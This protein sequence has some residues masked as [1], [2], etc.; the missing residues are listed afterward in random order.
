MNMKK[1]SLCLLVV[2]SFMAVAT[3]KAEGNV[4]ELPYTMVNGK[5]IVSA[6]VDGINGK[7]VFDTGAPFYISSAIAKKINVKDSKTQGII[8]SGGHELNVSKVKVGKV[9]FGESSTITLDSVEANVIPEGNIMEAFGVDGI[10]G[11]D[12]FVNKAV[13]FDSKAKKILIADGISQWKV[14]PRARVKMDNSNDQNIP[15]VTVNLGRGV[16]DSPMFDSGDATFF[17]LSEAAAEQGVVPGKAGTVVARGYGS[18]GMGLGGQAEKTN[19]MRVVLSDLR[20]GLGKFKNVSTT[21]IPGNG[22][23][24]GSALLDYGYVTLD[25][26]NSAFYFEPFDTNPV[27]M[28]KKEWNIGVTLDKAGHVIIS[29]VWKDNW[30]ASELEIGDRVIEVNG[31]KI[32]TVDMGEALRGNILK[33]GADSA[34]IKVMK[35]DGRIV[36]SVMYRK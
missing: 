18:T 33:V 30:N 9:T 12:F 14:N 29:A 8:D 24:F 1:I 32:D 17:S 35:A 19:L 22:S 25:N 7:F 28:Y 21:T 6:N 20:I 10:I 23:R 31:K 4:T 16:M 5:M 15:F 27:D 3:A 2:L 34:P 36:E 13:R 26:P 11:S